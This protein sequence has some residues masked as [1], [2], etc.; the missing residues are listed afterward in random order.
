MVVDATCLAD[1][2]KESP[3]LYRFVLDIG[4]LRYNLYQYLKSRGLK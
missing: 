3:E 1:F 4:S 2:E